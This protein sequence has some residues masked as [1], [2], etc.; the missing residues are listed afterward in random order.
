[1][2]S[3]H[4]SSGAI[5]VTIAIHQQSGV[6]FVTVLLYL[7]VLTF[8]GFAVFN[9]GLL[10]YKMS[11]QYLQAELALQKAETALLNAEALVNVNQINDKGVLTDGSTY[12]IEQ[13][14]TDNCGLELYKVQVRS[15]YAQAT[16]RLESVVLLPI[17]DGQCPDV[18]EHRRR[19]LWKQI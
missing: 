17:Y 1:M 2:E 6:V 16:S 15:E 10:Q 12:V 4:K 5:V 11:N 3:L 13:V 18:S 14:I 8:V 9:S 7:F 19:I